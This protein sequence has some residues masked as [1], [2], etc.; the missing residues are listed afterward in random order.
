MRTGEGKYKSRGSGIDTGRHRLDLHGKGVRQVASTRVV[1]NI[2][3]SAT[4]EVVRQVAST[5]VT[6]NTV[7]LR[8]PIQFARGRSQANGG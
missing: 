5:Q 2:N 7:H 4:D 3:Q 6:P 8:Q 1:R